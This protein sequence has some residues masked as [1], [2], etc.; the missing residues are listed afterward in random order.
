MNIHT[1]MYIYV[2]QMRFN[3]TELHVECSKDDNVLY[4]F[5]LML[6]GVFYQKDSPSLQL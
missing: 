6:G 1:Y 5:K 2:Y 3:G 4:I